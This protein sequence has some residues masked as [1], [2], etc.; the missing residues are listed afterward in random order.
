MFEYELIYDVVADKIRNNILND[1]DHCLLIPELIKDTFDKINKTYIR[2]K[3]TNFENDGKFYNGYVIFCNGKKIERI[4]R[5]DGTFI[6]LPKDTDINYCGAY[7][8]DD[9]LLVTINDEYA[10]IDGINGKILYL[11]KEYQINTLSNYSEGFAICTCHDK[12]FYFDKNFEKKSIEYEYASIFMNGRALVC[13]DTEWQIIDRNFNVLL[14]FLRKECNYDFF[15]RI[16]CDIEDEA[17]KLVRESVVD[18]RFTMF[19]AGKMYLKKGTNISIFMPWIIKKIADKFDLVVP[20][21][22]IKEQLVWLV[23]EVAKK[24][25]YVYDVENDEVFPAEL[26]IGIRVSSCDRSVISY[27]E[28]DVAFLRQKVK[29]EIADE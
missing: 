28:E 4:I 22:E 3:S 5:E 23:N 10:Y 20:D 13:T 8:S 7:F 18:E 16:L 24:G 11:P 2:L 26:Q 27:D 25:C 14:S 21:V 15:K 29:K 1:A 12:Q 17:K 9:L 19:S 6:T